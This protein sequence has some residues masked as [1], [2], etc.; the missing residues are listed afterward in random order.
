MPIKSCDNVQNR[1]IEHNVTF[2]SSNE[3]LGKVFL[4][5]QAK[6]VFLTNRY[7]YL[8]RSE[9]VSMKEMFDQW[10]KLLICFSNI[11]ESTQQT[12][13][14]THTHTYPHIHIETN[15]LWSPDRSSQSVQYLLHAGWGG[16]GGGGGWQVTATLPSPLNPN[17]AV[18]TLNCLM[19]IQNNMERGPV[20]ILTCD[21]IRILYTPPSCLP[22]IILLCHRTL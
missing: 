10:S 5:I 15:Y 8:K 4:N 6:Y 13:T 12:D 17:P 16:G 3:I 18:N 2:F 1:C 11:G 7:L 20:D 21:S 22:T 9:G 14:H 19:F